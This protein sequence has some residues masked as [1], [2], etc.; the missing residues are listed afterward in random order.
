MRRIT[1]YTTRQFLIY[2]DRVFYKRYIL[3]ERIGIILYKT[4]HGWGI[5]RYPNALEIKMAWLS[6]FIRR[7]E[8]WEL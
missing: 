4:S 2:P 5:L 8:E 3:W 1:H 6:I 7:K